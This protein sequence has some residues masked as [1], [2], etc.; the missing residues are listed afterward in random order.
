MTH[1]SAKLLA[2]SILVGSVI[3]ALG[4]VGGEFGAMFGLLAGLPVLLL[5]LMLIRNSRNS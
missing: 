2:G 5:G 4:S 3:I 1:Q